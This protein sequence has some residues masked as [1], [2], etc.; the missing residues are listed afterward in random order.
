MLAKK[1]KM[2]AVLETKNNDIDDEDNVVGLDHDMVYDD[3]ICPTFVVF[4]PNKFENAYTT[5]TDNDNKSVLVTNFEADEPIEVIKNYAMLSGVVKNA[6]EN[7]NEEPDRV[8]NDAGWIIKYVHYLKIPSLRRP[9]LLFVAEFLNQYKGV[10][11]GV[12]DAPIRSCDMSVIAKDPWIAEFF[13]K[14]SLEEVYTILY[15]SECLDIPPLLEHG[16]AYV[17]SRLKG[18]TIAEMNTML[19]L[20]PKEPVEANSATETDDQKSMIIDG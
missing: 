11:I 12:P 7:N 13:S 9:E 1:Q 19:G 18:K 4:V 8:L 3:T 5:S 15:A 20:R 10:D 6:F 16:C 2:S 14:K 17:A